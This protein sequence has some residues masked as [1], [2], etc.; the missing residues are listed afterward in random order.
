MKD[1]FVAHI[2]Q[3][4]GMTIPEILIKARKHVE[5]DLYMPN[6]SKGKLPDR[7]FVW[8]VGEL[9]LP[10]FTAVVNT[11]IPREL[12]DL[13]EKWLLNREDKFIKKRNLSM[14]VLPEFSELINNAPGLSSKTIDSIFCRNK[15]KI[16]PFGQKCW[17]QI[18][19]KI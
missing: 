7:S 10:S 6:L 13:T 18:G 3:I 2:P 14:K 5:I 1:L 8:N 11:L 17:A 16:L 19:R 12:R 4:N 15:R 9:A